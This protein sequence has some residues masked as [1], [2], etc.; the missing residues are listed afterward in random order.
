M[1]SLSYE[2]SHVVDDLDN[3]FTC[4]CFA[5][6]L[7]NTVWTG[8]Y[9]SIVQM[10]ARG[11]PSPMRGKKFQYFANFLLHPISFNIFSPL[12]FLNRQL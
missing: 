10:I 4:A 5:N 2:F 11:V 12:R 9:K 3:E 1:R 7:L 6:Y 8:E